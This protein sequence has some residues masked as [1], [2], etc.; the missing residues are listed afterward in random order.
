MPDFSQIKPKLK[1]GVEGQKE[2]STY[3]GYFP[4]LKTLITACSPA[5]FALRVIRLGQIFNFFM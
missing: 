1:S 3:R 4:A 5:Y 2:I